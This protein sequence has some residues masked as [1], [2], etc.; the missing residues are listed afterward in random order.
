MTIV[1]SLKKKTEGSPPICN[2]V[3]GPWGHYVKRHKLETELQIPDDLIYMWNL[4]TKELK[5]IKLVVRDLMGMGNGSSGRDNW[6]KVVKIYKPP[7]M[8][9]INIRD[10]H[11]HYSLHCC[12][13]YMEL[14]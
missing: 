14:W 5:E 9:W 2:K 3:N 12:M 13:V 10:V 11:D 6:I 8:Q 7:V 1:Q 4:K